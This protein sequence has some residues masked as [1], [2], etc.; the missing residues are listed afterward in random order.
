MARDEYRTLKKSFDDD[1]AFE[2]LLREETVAN[3]FR[4]RG[5]EVLSE[6]DDQTRAVFGM[7]RGTK[8]ADIV[9][10]VSPARAIVA[11][12][13]GRNGVDDALRQLETTARAVRTK[14]PVVECKVFTTI[15][16]PT[17]DSYTLRG[18]NF[19]PLGYRAVRMF[20]SGFPGEWPLFMLQP[21]GSSEAVRLGS[22]VVCVVFG[23]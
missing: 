2:S 12:I 4:S 7:P 5:Y 13:K 17:E 3:H 22:E 11:E 1:D 23:L 16:P 8:A 9:A 15:R 6:G 21:D 18:G 20:H 19:S 10:R 14:F